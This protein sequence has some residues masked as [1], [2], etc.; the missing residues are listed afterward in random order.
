MS[1]HFNYYDDW[2]SVE[3]ECPNCNWKG[4]FKEGSVGY[5]Q[6]L[7]DCSCPHCNFLDAPILAIVSYPTRDEMSSS[8]RSED[9]RYAEEVNQF[10]RKFE[11]LKL[12]SKDQL[13]DVDAAS[14]TLT[15]DFVVTDGDRSIVIRCGDRILFSEPALWE[16]YER[17][18]RVCEIIRQK[19]GER[20]LDVVPT[21]S[22]ELYLYGDVMSS[23]DFVSE[24]RRRIFGC[25][26]EA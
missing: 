7:M 16:G 6:E 18:E 9:V 11:A 4:K 13:P 26:E 10:Q 23:P 15:W 12:R 19:Y 20:V 14:F 17:F 22:S 8:G 2:Q 21:R 5:Y 24:A 25:E 1:K 3:L